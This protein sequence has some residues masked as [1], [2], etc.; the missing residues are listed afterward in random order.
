MCAGALQTTTQG[1]LEKPPPPLILDATAYNPLRLNFQ[2]S[3]AKGAPLLLVTTVG[4]KH[5]YSPKT[6]A[7]H[8]AR[9]G[10][11]FPVFPTPQSPNSK[12]S[13]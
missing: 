3:E 8:Q 7:H 13:F 11:I 12:P 5:N 1:K 4:I 9:P 6:R 10:F 2:M